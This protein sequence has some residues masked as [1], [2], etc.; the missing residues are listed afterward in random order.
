MRQTV[1]SVLLFKNFMKFNDGK[2]IIDNATT[3]KIIDGELYIINNI[4]TETISKVVW[5]ILPKEFTAR[6]MKL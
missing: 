1:E 6:L 5:V 2:T 3:Y 4:E